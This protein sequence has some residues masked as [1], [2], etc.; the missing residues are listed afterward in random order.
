MSASS[1]K[2]TFWKPGTSQPGSSLDRSTS[3]APLLPPPSTSPSTLPIHSSRLSILHALE[4]SQI[5]ILIG[6]T[7]SGK[8]TQLPIILHTSGW[9]SRGTI[10][11]TQPRRITATTV[12]A[13]VASSLAVPL[14]EEVGYTVRFE[15]DSSPRTKIRYMTHGALLRECLRDPLLTRYSVVMVDEVHERGLD[16]DLLLGILK[17][18]CRRRPEL[19]VVVASATVDVVGMKELLDG[20][21][22]TELFSLAPTGTRKVV[23]ATNVAETGITLDG[24]VYV[25][26]CGL[27]KLRTSSSLHSTLSVAPIS[28]ASALQR[29]GRAGRTRPGKCF[30]LYSEATFH[31]MARTT[32]PELTRVGL[33]GVVL[34][35]KC[36]GVDNL[37]S[38]PWLPPAPPVAALASA[39][40][41]LVRLGAIDSHSRLTEQGGMMGE[42]P[43]PPHL[44]RA[45]L[46]STRR[47]CASE[48]L[49]LLAM[50]SVTSPFFAVEST[51]TQLSMRA[52]QA[53]EGD[54]M[55]LLNVYLAFDGVGRRGRKW[56]TRHR[57][58][59]AALSRAVNIRSQLERYLQRFASTVKLDPTSSILGRQDAVERLTRCL[60]TGLYANL[61]R[62]DASTMTYRTAVGGDEVWVHP[63][64]VLFNRAPETGKL[65]VVYGEASQGD[66]GRIFIR[67]IAVLD[68]LT[69]VTD[70][71]PGFYDVKTHWGSSA[72]G[73]L[74][75][76]AGDESYSNL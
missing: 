59:F 8:T 24:I 29:A 15:D 19:R 3:S 66:D 1:S 32:A 75:T 13:H 71:V 48:T 10:A 49:S 42:L 11:C 57:L 21:G 65:W 55:T 45:L 44:S 6:S 70:A 37:L 76:S 34:Q 63:S 52:F 23:V 72:R 64:S 26:D 25:V 68:D 58:N 2:P 50:M 51:E 43:L 38:F 31:A 33:E 67:D 17:K 12:A 22:G 39:L 56:C 14:G 27:A 36:L 60:C 30:R 7:G 35:L 16:S 62:Y 61:A 53:K 9:S 5:L 20:P 69:W 28:Q 4:I 47:G 73:T 18:I 74:Q 41:R 54:M 40:G 46:E